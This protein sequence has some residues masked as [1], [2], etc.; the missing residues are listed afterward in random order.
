MK[1]IP[2]FPLLSPLACRKASNIL[3][4]DRN[5]ISS[6]SGRDFASTWTQGIL[7]CPEKQGKG[8][9]LFSRRRVISVILLCLVLHC[10]A[11][12]SAHHIELWE[13]KGSQ[14]SEKNP[15]FIARGLGIGD[16]RMWEKFQWAEERNP[17]ILQ[18][19][20]T[21]S[22][23]RAYSPVAPVKTQAFRTELTS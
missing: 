7:S 9:L 20:V 12:W 14:N 10:F 5:H 2:W 11:L 13:N 4:L 3:K 6:R 19:W 22:R 8:T 17:L 18:V 1:R 23:T 16:L 15:G 21:T